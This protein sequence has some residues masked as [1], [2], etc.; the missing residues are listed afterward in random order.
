MLKKLLMMGAAI[1]LAGAVI[2]A[3]RLFRTP[4]AASGPLTAAPIVLEATSGEDASVNATTI[5]TTTT[6]DNQEATSATP[7]DGVAADPVVTTSEDATVTADT[8]AASPIIFEIQQDESEAR[9][10][11]N[12]VL[13][14]AP[15]TVIGVTDQVAGQIAIDAANPSAT[16]LGLIQ[17]NARTLA[18]DN[19]MRNRAIKNAI[20]ATNQYEFVTF[21]PTAL[22][23]LPVEAAVGDSYSFEVTGDLTITDVTRPVT[24]TVTVTPVSASRLEGTATATI[25]YRDFDLFIP[26]SPSV[27]TVE[28][29]V[30][31]ELHFVAEA[32]A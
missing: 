8:E 20:L 25:L 11:I 29:T 13:R 3:Y 6:S 27:D 15:T 30:T 4:E 5:E 19:E 12:E 1:V 31:L 14:G 22:S 10:V 32:M 2:V 28:D 7:A 23:G 16:Q 26:D 9:F 18:T 17:V 21:A 24:F